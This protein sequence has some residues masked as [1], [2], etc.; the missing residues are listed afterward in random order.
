MWETDLR[1]KIRNHFIVFGQ[2]DHLP[3]LL[4]ALK[5][6]T[7]QYVWYEISIPLNSLVLF[8]TNSLMKDGPN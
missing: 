3:A 4:L 2:L 5:H 1:S 8:L 6:Y 7:K